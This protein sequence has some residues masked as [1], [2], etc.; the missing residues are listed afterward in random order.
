MNYAENLDDILKDI[1]DER[2]KVAAFICESVFSVAGNF[3]P[4]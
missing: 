2:K 3:E 1:T 4:P